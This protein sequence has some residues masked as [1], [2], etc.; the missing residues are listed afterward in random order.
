MSYR[1]VCCCG[2]ENVKGVLS[3]ELSNMQSSVIKYSHP[4]VHY[5][6]MADLFYDWSF[7]PFD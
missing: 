2:G 7:E 3:Q 4:T 6:P 1:I 5:I